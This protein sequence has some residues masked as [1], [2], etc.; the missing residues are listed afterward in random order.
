VTRPRILLAGGG[1]G[2]HVFPAIA[3]AEAIQALADVEVVF[4]GTARG[5][6]A[7]EVPARG[8]RLELL[9]VEPMRGRGAPRALRAAF[10]AARATIRGLALVHRMKPR[11]VLGVGG[12]AA[13]PVTLAAAMHGVPIAVLEPNSV[14]GL[15]NRLVAPFVQ[16]AY[17]AWDEAAGRF[18]SSARRV[19]GVPLRKGF[20]P[21]P[22]TPRGTG[23]LLVMGGSQGAAALNERLP[24]AVAHLQGIVPGLDVVHQAGRDRDAAVREAYARHGVEHAVVVPFLDDV[25]GA[26]ADADLVVA[27]AGAG[28]IAEI[29]AVGR[30]AILIPLP[31]AADDHQ[32][33]N[34]D[35][36]A[37]AGAALCVR[38]EAADAARLS[39]EIERLLRGHTARAAMADAARSRGKPDAAREVARDLLALAGIGAGRKT[40]NGVA[41][42]G[43]HPIEREVR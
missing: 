39:G 10:V 35:A 20:T 38:Q 4:C 43:R 13:G 9:D 29:A 22:Y 16:R 3:V 27:R 17:V 34:A 26:I 5:L 2:G 33:R 6:E 14:V 24:E 41:T 30:A 23:R 15:A 18:R 31:H 28:T 42:A 37:R 19:Y 36:L 21:R 12:Y 11:V 1:T 8:W 32:G 7:R 25:A 40:T